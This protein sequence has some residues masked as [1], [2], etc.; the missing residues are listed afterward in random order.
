[1]IDIGATHTLIIRSF[2]DTFS[3]ARIQKT[4][5]TTT[6]L[7]DASI[8]ISV[9]GIVRL[10]IYINCIPAYASVFVVDS[11]R[12]DF[13]LGMDWRHTYDLVLRIR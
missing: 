6:M 8:T 12:V 7:G 3:H 4:S 10:C 2:L 9:H 11:L 1:M 5:T 13:I